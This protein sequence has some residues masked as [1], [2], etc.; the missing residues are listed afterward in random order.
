MPTTDRNDEIEA[1]VLRDMGERAAMSRT[2]VP[3][4]EFGARHDRVANATIKSKRRARRHAN[5]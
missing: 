5:Y 1:V 3:A 2:S 4:R